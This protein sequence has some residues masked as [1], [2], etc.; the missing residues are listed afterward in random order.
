MA[1]DWP[2]Y[3]LSWDAGC[4]WQAKGCDLG[5]YGAGFVALLLNI[6]LWKR[7]GNMGT[8]K[9]ASPL[10]LFH[11]VPGPVQIQRV[12]VYTHVCGRGMRDLC[13]RGGELV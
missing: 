3:C 13:K 12:H 1:I 9:P 4:I 6:L 2:I 5:G 11:V 8:S 10:W 7:S